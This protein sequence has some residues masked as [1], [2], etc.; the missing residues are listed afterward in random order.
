MSEKE[1]AVSDQNGLYVFIPMI[2]LRPSK[3]M[4][5]IHMEKPLSKL[6]DAISESICDEEE[7]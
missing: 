1:F 6:I 3:V 4:N 5:D 2:I 7:L